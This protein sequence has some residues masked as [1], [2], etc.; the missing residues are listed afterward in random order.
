MQ[1]PSWDTGE[2]S[3]HVDSIWTWGQMV[4]LT[5]YWGKS[6]RPTKDWP[7]GIYFPLAKHSDFLLITDLFEQLCVSNL[8]VRLLSSPPGTPS[9]W[10]SDF[11]L[12]LLSLVFIWIWSRYREDTF[13][14]HS[15][16]LG[17]LRTSWQEGGDRDL[18]KNTEKRMSIMS[19]DYV[20]G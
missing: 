7:Q 1:S 18:K 11:L 13:L 16:A 20:K 6:K 12:T 3:D 17:I 19:G 2:A 14:V 4:G 10:L 5:H 9:L 8:F 15:R